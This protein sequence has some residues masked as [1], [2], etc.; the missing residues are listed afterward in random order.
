MMSSIIAR[1]SRLYV[2]I[3]GLRGQWKRVATPFF[4]T[5]E[6]RQSAQA[7]LD[8]LEHTGENLLT[9]SRRG[10]LEN[11]HLYAIESSCGH[12]KIGRAIDVAKRLR[13]LQAMCPPSV[14]LSVLATAERCG[15]LEREIHGVFAGHRI[16]GE[17]FS[18]AVAIRIR[19]LLQRGSF[20]AIVHAL[21]TRARTK[22]S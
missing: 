8:G 10:T 4:D 18:N 17:W 21:V 2:K 1:G 22:N 5:P 3:K 20:T 9:K 6:G 15:S 11:D 7:M 16:R 19:D 12:V 13:D 14:A